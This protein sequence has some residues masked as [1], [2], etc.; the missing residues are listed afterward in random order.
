MADGDV[1]PEATRDTRQR[2][3]D[4]EIE[5]QGGGR[6]AAPAAIAISGKETT[7]GGGGGW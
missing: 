7:A 5:M 1:E 6:T 3:T 2:D 4:G